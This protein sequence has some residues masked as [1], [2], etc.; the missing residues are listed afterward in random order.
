MN[1][2]IGAT[3]SADAMLAAFE[4]DGART[5]DAGDGTLDGQ[6]ALKPLNDLG[7]AERLITRFGHDFLFLRGAGWAAWDGAVW[8]LDD[9]ETRIELAAH[10]TAR[11]LLDE[12]R[13][14]GESLKGNKDG[15]ER[16]EQFGRFASRS[17]NG[18]PLAAMVRRAQPVLTVGMETMDAR[19]DLFN[20]RNGTLDLSGLEPRLIPHDRQHRITRCANAAYDPDARC[21]Q[22]LR[23]AETCWPGG[24]LEDGGSALELIQAWLGYCLTGH[25]GEQKILCLWGQ[26]ANGKSTLLSVIERVLG[27]YASTL[28]FAS[29][30]HDDRRR[31]SEAT[32]D[33]ARLPGRRFVVASEPDRGAR[34]SESMIKTLTGGDT[35]IARHLHHGF[36]EFVPEFKLTLSFNAKPRI[37][38]GDEGIWRRL[39]LVPCTTFIPPEK[40]DAA[41]PAKL[42]GEAS[43]ILNWLLDGWRAWRRSGLPMPSSVK[44]A[45]EAYRVVSDPLGSWLE[46]ATEPAPGERIAAKRMFEC[47]VAYCRENGEEPVNPNWFGRMLTDRNVARSKIGGVNYY[48]DRRLTVE[49]QGA[50]AP[51]K[52]D[53]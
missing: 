43:G 9:G 18:Q 47:Y 41:L 42:M 40:R 30:L 28:P 8:N 5:L 33:L 19:P 6:L 45:T 38:G 34:F 25:T 36:F 1:G 48:L 12:T 32:P 17:G 51:V 49:A 37:V 20:C 16:V 26:G 2:L 31:G 15:G 27:S 10:A 3:L 53:D 50:G 35:I 7:N 23:F 4:A 24:D 14:L 44:A 52:Q 13:R 22:F 46:W 29:L 11:A 21:E 39:I